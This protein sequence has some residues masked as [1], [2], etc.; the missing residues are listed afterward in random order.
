MSAEQTGREAKN[1]AAMETVELVTNGQSTG[2]DQARNT[3]NGHPHG[4]MQRV[5]NFVKKKWKVVIFFGGFIFVASVAIAFVIGHST[6]CNYYGKEVPLPEKPCS[7]LGPK[8]VSYMNTSYFYSEDKK[9]WS[10]SKNFCANQGT[11]LAVLKDDLV[12]KNVIRFKTDGDDYWCGSY[13]WD[14]KWEWLNE[15]SLDNERLDSISGENCRTFNPKEFLSA[16]C[17]KLNPFICICNR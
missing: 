16:D 14:N 7:S 4:C 8:W 3:R 5:W 1:H 6:G 15:T 2:G 12:K 9:N 10:E 17:S 13:Q 11:Q